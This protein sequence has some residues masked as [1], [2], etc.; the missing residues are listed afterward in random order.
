[1]PPCPS[2]TRA[3]RSPYPHSRI[4]RSGRHFPRPVR[5]WARICRAA[6]RPDATACPTISDLR[7]GCLSHTGSDGCCQTCSDMRRLAGKSLCSDIAGT[8]T[9][10]PTDDNRTRRGECRAADGRGIHVQVGSGH[11]SG[12]RQPRYPGAVGCARGEGLR[13][14]RDDNADS[15]KFTSASPSH[16]LL[17][18]QTAPA[19]S[20][21]SWI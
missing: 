12:P 11:K 8:A 2:S 20:T 15:M 6:M 4:P 1:M 13:Y 14:A 16:G 17:S 10:S 19:A 7:V 9:H 3:R 18:R 21:C 5:R